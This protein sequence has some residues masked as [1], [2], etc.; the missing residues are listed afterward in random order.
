[1]PS[2]KVAAE[3]YVSGRVQGV[4]YRFFTERAA[5]KYN[6][7]GW[8]RNLPDGSVVLEI[9]AGE[10]DAREFIKELE[11]GPAMARVEDVKVDWKTYTGRFQNFTIKV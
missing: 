2:R 9:E 3:I 11:K 4:G 5:L 10:E 8:S 1:M 7:R 6:V